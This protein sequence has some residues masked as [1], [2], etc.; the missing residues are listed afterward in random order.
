VQEDAGI[1]CPLGVHVA[2]HHVVLELKRHC[3]AGGR[4]AGSRREAVMR[5]GEASGCLHACCVGSRQAAASIQTS[6]ERQAGR[7]AR[8]QPAWREPG[9]QQACSRRGQARAL[10]A[11][12][13]AGEGVGVEGVAAVHSRLWHPHAPYLLLS[14]AHLLYLVLHSGCSRHSRHSRRS[15]GW[16][17]GNSERAACQAWRA[18]ALRQRN[19]TSWAA[20]HPRTTDI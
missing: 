14:L 2:P 7:Q 19:T 4:Q 1:H 13:G 8:C 20:C 5:Q 18:G 6:Q 17:F 10:T 3:T 16:C 12:V 11:A 9:M 15:R